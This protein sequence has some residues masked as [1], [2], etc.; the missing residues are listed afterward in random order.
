LEIGLKINSV[1]NMGVI[2]ILLLSVL[3]GI[4][5]VYTVKMCYTTDENNRVDKTTVEIGD[6]FVYE[7]LC[8]KT[9]PFEDNYTVR[10]V[11]S[12]TYIVDD[13]KTNYEGVVWVK[14]HSLSSHRRKKCFYNTSS[15]D[16]FLWRTY[17]HNELK[18]LFE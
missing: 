17:K 12:R 11:D 14:Y 10:D 16:S 1:Y 4:F 18:H 3:V 13:L 7:P 15:I 5:I 9:D 2:W 6:V 8:I